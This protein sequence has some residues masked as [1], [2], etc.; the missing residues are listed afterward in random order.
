MSDIGNAQN[1]EQNLKTYIGL[2]ITV[3]K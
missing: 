2:N 3:E 1:V